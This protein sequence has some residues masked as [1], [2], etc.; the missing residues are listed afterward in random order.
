MAAV[1]K[2]LAITLASLVAIAGG[3]AVVQAFTEPSV[4]PA[5]WTENPNKFEPVLEVTPTQSS[6]SW[7]A[8]VDF[9]AN[10]NYNGK[11]DWRLPT[12]E[13]LAYAS[14]AFGFTEYAYIWTRTPYFGSPNNW[15]RFTP[16][17]G[18]WHYSTY[19]DTISFRCVR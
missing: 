17:N 4:P 16:S 8:A 19:N 18:S 12:V 13:E 14:G 11:T 2:Q 3:F 6:R 10:L 7:K 15:V 9:C 5:S 1:G